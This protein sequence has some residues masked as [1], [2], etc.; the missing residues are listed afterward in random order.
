MGF[1]AYQSVEPQ[2]LLEALDTVLENAA[3]QLPLGVNIT[4]VADNWINKGGY[5]VLNVTL[6]GTDII[7]TQ[8]SFYTFRLY[9]HNVQF[10]ISAKIP[11]YSNRRRK[12]FLVRPSKLHHLHF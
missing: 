1:S 4:T 5:P 10:E 11:L 8:V 2:D 12:L 7:I 6:N 9:G 3:P